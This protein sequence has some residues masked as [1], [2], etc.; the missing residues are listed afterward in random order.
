MYR[1]KILCPH[2]LIWLIAAIFLFYIPIKINVTKA[3][4][5]GETSLVPVLYIDKVQRFCSSYMIN[6]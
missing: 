2:T 4:L 5:E 3:R 6:N 1:V